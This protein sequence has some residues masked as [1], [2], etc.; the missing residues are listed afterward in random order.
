[1]GFFELGGKR[2]IAGMI[3]FGS[4]DRKI[5]NTD[6]TVLNGMEKLPPIQGKQR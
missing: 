5:L 1:M 2:A 3:E 6:S 4:R